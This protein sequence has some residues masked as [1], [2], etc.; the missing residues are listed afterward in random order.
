MRSI[1]GYLGSTFTPSSATNKTREAEE[2][3]P[4]VLSKLASVLWL[5]RQADGQRE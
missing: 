3:V 2:A 4:E 1:H 5:V